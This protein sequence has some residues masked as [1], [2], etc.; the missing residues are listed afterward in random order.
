MNA[1]AAVHYVLS[2]NSTYNAHVGGSASAARIY[3]D[4]AEQGAAYPQTVITA[5]GVDPTDT[6]TSSNFDH[7]YIQVFHSAKYG[8]GS[9]AKSTALTM[10]ANARTALE[11]AS[12]TL[13][14]VSVAEIRYVDQSSFTERVLDSKIQTIEQIYKVTVKL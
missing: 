14:G 2:N 6:K 7:D 10:A 9:G 8:S 1:E 12:G 13:N 3:Y 11:A 4:G 5:E